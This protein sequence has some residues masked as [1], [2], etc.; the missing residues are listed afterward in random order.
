MGK[1][2]GSID[3]IIW[4]SNVMEMLCKDCRY[5]DENGLLT[6]FSQKID[7]TTGRCHRNALSPK[8]SS[9]HLTN[10]FELEVSRMGHPPEDS[11]QLESAIGSLLDFGG[12]HS[13]SVEDAKEEA[14]LFG[15]PIWPVVNDTDW[16]GEFSERE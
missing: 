5:F 12:G 11:D 2:A 8:L 10:E 14:E 1:I 4:A 13:Q 3:A 6:G 9:T 15:R 16:C 7:P